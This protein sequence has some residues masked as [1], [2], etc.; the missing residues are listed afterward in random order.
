[1]DLV[2]FIVEL[3]SFR[4]IKV[5]QIPFFTSTKSKDGVFL[6]E[7]TPSVIHLPSRFM[8][9]YYSYVVHLH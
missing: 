9:L 7:N 5:L 6:S 4:L 3:I 8:C 1:M 2:F